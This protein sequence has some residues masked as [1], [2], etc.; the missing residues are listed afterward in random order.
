MPRTEDLA[1][2]PFRDLVDFAMGLHVLQDSF[3]HAGAYRRNF[4]PKVKQIRFGRTGLAWAEHIS[5]D[6]KNPEEGVIH[7]FS[8]RDVQR[9]GVEGGI[10]AV[11]WTFMNPAKLVR[12]A[13][14]TYDAM[15][16]YRLRNGDITVF[17]AKNLRRKW[18]S[19]VGVIEEF[20]RA[21]TIEAKKKWFSRY[22]P[23]ALGVLPW[24]DLSLHLAEGK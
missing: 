20:A 4:M 12:A 3:S 15:I 23:R 6:V 2:W 13:K 10:H 7:D 17:E 16:D 21:S 22:L 18:F 8:M 5:R 11:D 14:A 1:P 19:I 24:E 9:F